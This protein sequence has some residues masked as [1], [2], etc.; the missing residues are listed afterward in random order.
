MFD[1][2]IFNTN[3]PKSINNATLTITIMNHENLNNDHVMI[4]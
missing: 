3:C 2:N 4:A 1:R